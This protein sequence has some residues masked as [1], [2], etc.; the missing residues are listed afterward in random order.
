MKT[1]IFFFAFFFFN[2]FVSFSQDTIAIKGLKVIGITTHEC[3]TCFVI[4]NGETIMKKNFLSIFNEEI[5][6]CPD[7]QII[8]FVI[9]R[10]EKVGAI[11]RTTEEHF[12]NSSTHYSNILLAEKFKY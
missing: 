11:L 3:D 9:N 12:L 1:L 8:G 4:L 2:S 7:G 5:N 10:Q 6:N